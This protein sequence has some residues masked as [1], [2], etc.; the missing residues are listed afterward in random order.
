[1]EHSRAVLRLFCPDR[2]GLVADVSGLLFRLG[3]NILHADQHL[4]REANTFFQRIE[5]T[6]AKG[7]EERGRVHRE[8]AQQFDSWHTRWSLRFSEDE[9]PRVAILA[10]KRG[11]CPLDLLFRHQ[12][13][14][15]ECEIPFVA[16]NHSDLAEEVTRRGY[17]F[18]H[19]PIAGGDK[20]GQ[21]LRLQ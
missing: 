12:A 18:I 15:L 4:D 17:R 10:S 14:E 2:P 9:R 7:G 16:S 21:E 3:A 1:V 5:F 6:L 11:H 19:E 20:R 13:G 8:L